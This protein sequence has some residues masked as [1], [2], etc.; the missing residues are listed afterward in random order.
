MPAVD[1]HPSVTRL[2][3]PK[4]GSTAE[5]ARKWTQKVDTPKSGHERE[6]GHEPQKVDIQQKVDTSRNLVAYL[7]DAAEE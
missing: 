1:V 5:A 6:S 7:T 2:L 4:F 3:S